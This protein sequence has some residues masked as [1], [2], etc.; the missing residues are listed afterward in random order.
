MFKSREEGQKYIEETEWESDE[1]KANAQKR[2][3]K[4]FPK[5]E[6]NAFDFYNKKRMKE[7]E[8]EE[9]EPKKLASSIKSV[10]DVKNVFGKYLKEKE[11]KSLD[12]SKNL[13]ISISKQYKGDD[14]YKIIDDDY[15]KEAFNS[16]SGTLKDL[17]R[18]M[19]DNKENAYF[20]KIR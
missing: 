15:I 19:S 17:Q 5:K 14:N 10:E 6:E 20:I 7:S 4:A 11:L 18:Y 2:L 1:D 3:D 16:G 8:S 13:Y 12:K 9:I